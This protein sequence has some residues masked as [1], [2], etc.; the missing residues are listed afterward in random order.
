M[1]ASTLPAGFP[2][3]PEQ[4]ANYCHYQHNYDDQCYGPLHLISLRSKRSKFHS[5]LVG[6]EASGTAKFSIGAAP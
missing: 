2:E 6:D 4:V 3:Y 5:C 1:N